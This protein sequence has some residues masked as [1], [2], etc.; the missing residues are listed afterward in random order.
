[1]KKF[2]TIAAMTVLALGLQAQTR[3]S[4]STYNGT[5]LER[6]DG[7]VCNVTVNRYMFTGWN[8]IALPFAM[9]EQ[10]LNEIF[11]TDCRLERL[12]GVEDATEGITLN[13]I[14]CK[15]GGM[16]ANTP[17]MLYYTGETGNVR[18][19]AEATIAN[20]Q[21]ALSYTT[22]NGE[23]VTMEAARTH[24]DGEGLYG[25][26]ARDNSE[27]KFVAVGQ[28]HTSG[29]YATRCYIRLSSGTSQMLIARHLGYGDATSINAIATQDELV[30]VY[31]MQ[32][33]KVASQVRAAEVNSLRPAIYIV[34]GQK[35]L[36]R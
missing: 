22:Q 8:T 11:G 17:Y 18:I 30:D 9:S 15:A 1:M 12:I 20:R 29:F 33:A 13:F 28:E 24:T 2:F 25:V 36:V 32:G 23:V 26:L 16:E 6:Y 14:N 27:V 35:V 4:L 31:N 19:V 7:Q 10:Q 3:L 5:N 34:K 21:A